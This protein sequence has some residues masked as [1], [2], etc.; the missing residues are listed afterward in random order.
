MRHGFDCRL[1]FLLDFS[2]FLAIMIPH[3]AAPL[4][5]RSNAR[6]RST[7]V[8]NPEF[9]SFPI[10]ILMLSVFPWRS[11]GSPPWEGWVC[12][13]AEWYL[14]P[15][16]PKNHPLER[17]EVPLSVFFHLIPGLSPGVRAT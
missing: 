2:W 8:G 4:H 13:S 11:L 12:W 14:P 5:Y 3:E 6:D 7:N 1:P 17:L 9:L 16:E 10:L 15:S